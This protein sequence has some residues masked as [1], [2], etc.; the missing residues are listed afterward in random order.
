MSYLQATIVQ[1]TVYLTHTGTPAASVAYSAVTAKIK[2]EGQS[3]LS[4]WT[5][6]ALNW[7]NL[8]GGFYSIQFSAIDTATAGD[9]TFTLSGAGF[10]NFTFGEFSIEPAPPTLPSQCVVSGT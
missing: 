4:A 9:F 7:I 6:T 1:R 2:K 5:V 8:G 10:D 3:S